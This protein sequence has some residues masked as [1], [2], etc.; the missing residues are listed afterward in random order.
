MHELNSANL[1]LSFTGFADFETSQL[2]EGEWVPR[3]SSGE[4]DEGEAKFHEGGGRH[5]I[6]VNAEQ[7]KIISQVAELYQNKNEEATL[8]EALVAICKAYKP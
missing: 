4:G 3:Q 6:T 1:D 2:M 8:G 5:M 7:W